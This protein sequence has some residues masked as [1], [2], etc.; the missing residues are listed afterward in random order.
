MKI[1][2]PEFHTQVLAQMPIRPDAQA[3]QAAQTY[4]VPSGLMVS[5][6]SKC[7]MSVMPIDVQRL[8]G[9]GQ[10]SCSPPVSALHPAIATSNCFIDGQQALQTILLILP[11]RE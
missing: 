9:E 11:D 3:A 10:V 8:R 5:K 4:I 2:L 1:R 6:L 7:M